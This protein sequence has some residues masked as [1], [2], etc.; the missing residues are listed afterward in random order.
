MAFLEFSR[1][2]RNQL[3]ARDMAV[4]HLYFACDEMI[5]LPRFYR[6]LDGSRVPQ[7]WELSLIEQRLGITVPYRYLRGEDKYGRQIKPENKQLN[8][9]GLRGR[10]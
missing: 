8:L 3:E 10:R 5:P 4:R 1:F 2:L 6:F 9:P 7:A